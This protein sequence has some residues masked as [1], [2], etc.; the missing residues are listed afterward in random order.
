MEKKKILIIDDEPD[1]L[2]ALDIR[3]SK[4]GYEV[5]KA[6]NGEQAIAIAQAQVP[7]LIILDIIMPG[8]NGT[9]TA[10]ILKENEK[11]K[12]F[13]SFFLH[14]CLVYP[15]CPLKKKNMRLSNFLLLSPLT[16]KSFWKL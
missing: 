10:A 13:L 3:L 5:L 12:I 15:I 6:I 2:E 4:A 7:H 8:M 11:P 1:I 16:I 14:A 9:E